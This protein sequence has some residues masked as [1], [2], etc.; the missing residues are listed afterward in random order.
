M[1]NKPPQQP[2][3]FGGQNYD[4]MNNQASHLNSYK[5]V[6]D[7]L[8]EN[9]PPILA[10]SPKLNPDNHITGCFEEYFEKKSY[11]ESNA[12]ELCAS[13]LKKLQITPT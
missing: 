5:A 9:Q 2:S 11:R 1:Q 3:I 7:E 13:Q 4:N 8:D 12:S 6:H 10:S